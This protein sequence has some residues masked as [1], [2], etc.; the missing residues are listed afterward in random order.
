MSNLR[1]FLKCSFIY[2]PALLLAI[3]GS[4][5]LQY[6]FLDSNP[7]YSAFTAAAA[8]MG[9]TILI[10]AAIVLVSD[11]TAMVTYLMRHGTRNE[12]EGC[13]NEEGPVPVDVGMRPGRSKRKTL[14]RRK[15][16]ISMKSLARGTATFGGRMLVLGAFVWLASFFSIFLGIGLMLMEGL[17]VMILLPAI[18]GIFIFTSFLRPAWSDYRE[19]KAELRRSDAEDRATSR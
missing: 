3:I 5:L 4:V 15:E 17:F 18:P 16:F 1:F 7:G 19:A 12:S 9:R 2:V 10:V 14:V 11:L 13:V 6:Q 8:R